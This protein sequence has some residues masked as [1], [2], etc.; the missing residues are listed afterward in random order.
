VRNY[1]AGLETHLIALRSIDPWYFK[2]LH[3]GVEEQQ[4]QR[5]ERRYRGVGGWLRTR[6]AASTVRAIW[7]RAPRRFRL[8]TYSAA[9]CLA[10]VNAAE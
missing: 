3:V 10:S 4:A 9:V 2:G 7:S 6:A 1:E 8:R 5:C